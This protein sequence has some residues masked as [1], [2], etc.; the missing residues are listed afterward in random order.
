MAQR[1]TT[2]REVQGTK[3]VSRAIHLL[4]AVA[5]CNEVG[6]HLSTLARNVGLHVVTARRLLAVLVAEGLISFDPQAKTY[7]IGIA[8]YHLGSAAK[9]FDIRDR[10][11]STL[12]KIADK[13]EDT[14]FL[15][16]RQ[17]ND[18]I[19]IDRIEGRFPIRALLV[20]VGTSRPLGIG[21]SS[22]ALIAFL[23]DDQFDEVFAANLK[24]YESFPNWTP[25]LILELARKSQKRGYVVSDSYFWPG[26][27]AVSVPVFDVQGSVIAAVS[28]SAI[29]SRM[30]RAR[31]VE[32]SEIIKT[33]LE[34]LCL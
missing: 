17:G 1:G 18:S 4:R 22:L 32:V 33:H 14:V 3:S 28:V 12:E 13:T 19:C 21:A 34:Q 24:N 6:G 29:S 8:L 26:V 9:Q 11:R 20:D 10:L 16:V 5:K 30:K 25:Q 15:F 7:R 27:T 31:Q 23:P 2:S